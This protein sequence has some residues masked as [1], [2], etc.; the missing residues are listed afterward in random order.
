VNAN[1][2]NGTDVTPSWDVTADG[3]RFLFLVPESDNTL[4]P[5]TVLLNW[6]RPSK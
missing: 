2:Q 5:F 1:A 6:Q 4:V 3:R